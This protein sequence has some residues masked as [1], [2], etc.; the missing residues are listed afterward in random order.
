M[1]DAIP[2]AASEKT[3]AACAPTPAAPAV[4]ATVFKVKIAANLFPVR[5]TFV[6]PM[7]PEPILRKFPSPIILAIIIPEGIDP[8]KYEQNITN[9]IFKILSSNTGNISYKPLFL[10]R[11]FVLLYLALFFH[12][13]GYFLILNVV[14]IYPE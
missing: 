14:L 2:T 8:I 9:R 6:A 4:W 5:R 1:A 13:M 7:L 12:R 11:L 10:R 3:T